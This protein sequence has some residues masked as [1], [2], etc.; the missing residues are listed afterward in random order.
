MSISSDVQPDLREYERGT[1]N[2]YV[3]PL[4]RH[5]VSRLVEAFRARGFG[6]QFH[7]VQ[8][9]GGLTS[10]ETASDLPVRLIESGPAGGGLATVRLGAKAGRRDA[11]SF[12]MGGTTATACLI[13]DGMLDN[14]PTMEVARVHRFKRGSGLPIKAPTLDMIE[15]GAGGGIAHVGRLGLLRVGPT[16]AGAEPGPA[17]YGQG[18]AKPTVTDANLVLDYLNPDFFLGGRMRLDAA[19]AEAALA[20]I[21]EPLALSTLDA[22]WVVYDIVCESMAAEARVHI[23]RKGRDPR[24]YAM[25]AMGGAG[26]AHAARVA[27]K[28]GVGEVLVP[29]ASGAASAL[30]FLVAPVSFEAIKS[31]PGLV[32]ELDPV[33]VN[34]LLAQLEAE[35]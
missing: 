2:A 7:L 33:A 32:D 11:I 22:T 34:G 1:A 18:G 30:G 13:Q 25:V 3:Q 29:P 9:S 10:P 23:V 17:C 14:A 21:A 5:Y 15:I 19:A 24:R 12:D 35:G 28:L 8:S 4:V 26:P 6:G 31:L 16:S 20:R 27:R